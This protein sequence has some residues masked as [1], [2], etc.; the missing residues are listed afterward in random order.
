MATAVVPLKLGPVEKT[1]LEVSWFRW[2]GSQ[3]KDGSEPLY[4]GSFDQVLSQ[5]LDQAQ[6]DQLIAASERHKASGRGLGN[7]MAVR[8]AS[9][10][11][12]LMRATGGPDVPT[13]DATNALGVVRKPWTLSGLP[14]SD[15]RQVVILGAGLDTRAWRL[16]WPAGVQIYEVDTGVTEAVKA[17]VLAAHP[18]RAAGRHAL[19]ADLSEAHLLGAVL[20]GAGF[21]SSKPTVWVLEGLIGYLTLEHGNALLRTT[22][23]LSAPGSQFLLTCPPMRSELEAS[24]QPGALPLHHSIY[25]EPTDTYARVKA[26]GWSEAELVANTKL[27][28]IYGLSIWQSQVH[29]HKA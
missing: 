29:A 2:Q 6:V 15:I 1:A 18:L 3:P 22:Y 14:T 9:L 19:V 13:A 23:Q 28:E 25:E 4:D 5:Y 26:A 20:A 11:D 24:K 12:A 7:L 10:D 16:Y 8:T 21:N 17:K 27:E